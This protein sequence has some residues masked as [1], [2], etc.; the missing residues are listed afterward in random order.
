MTTEID[1]SGHDMAETLRKDRRRRD[2]AELSEG[3]GALDAALLPLSIAIARLSARVT[4]AQTKGR[5]IQ[6]D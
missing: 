3:M 4:T 6:Q 1:V 2:E 5:A